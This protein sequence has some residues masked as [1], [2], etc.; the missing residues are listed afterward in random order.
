LGYS[1]DLWVA[2]AV[3]TTKDT[4]I[5][6]TLSYAVGQARGDINLATLQFDDY[7]VVDQAYLLVND[8]STFSADIQAEGYDGLIGLGPNSG[9]VVFRELDK[10][11]KGDSVLNRIFSQ[12]KTSQNYI[13]V[14]LDRS[15]DAMDPWTGQMTI[16]EIIPELANIT[17]QPKLEVEK[18]HK[19]TSRDQH[20]QVLL[21]KVSYRTLI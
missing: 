17:A 16:S 18:V 9:S 14:L 11:V 6:T 1:S 21:D 10:E 3:T 13:S 2:G 4:G 5:S 15:G 12:N 8:T 19:L 20:W 7:S